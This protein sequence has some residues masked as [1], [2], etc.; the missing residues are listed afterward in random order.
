MD[1]VYKVS[2]TFAQIH[3]DPNPMIFVMGPVG[4]GKSSGCIWH[5]VLNAMKQHPDSDGV[6]HYRHLVVRATYPALRSTVIKTWIEWFKDKITITY[7]TPILGKLR[8]PLAD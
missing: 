3:R 8:Y 5:A 7:T 6:R 4:S 1:V 2:N